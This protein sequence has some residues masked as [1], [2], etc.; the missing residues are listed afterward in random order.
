[1]NDFTKAS[2]YFS[3]DTERTIYLVLNDSGRRKFEII[4]VSKSV[5]SSYSNNSSADINK[6]FQ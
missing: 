6:V 1:M 2:S 3:R 4:W 5:C